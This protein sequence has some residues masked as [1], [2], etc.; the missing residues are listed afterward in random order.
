MKSSQSIILWN[1]VHYYQSEKFSKKSPLVFLHGWGQNGACFKK[2]FKILDEKNISYIALD[3]PWFGKTPLKNEQMH[4]EDYGHFVE[5]FIE[6]F[7][8][9]H[10]LLIWHSFGGRIC[11]YLWSYYTN[12]S[13]IILIWSAGLKSKQNY[14]KLAIIKS[15]KYIFKI[16]GLKTL[17]VK[18]R[19][20]AIS[21][22]NK[23]AGKMAKIFMHTINNDLKKYMVKIKIP[24]LLIRWENDDQTPLSE[25]Q[26]INSQITDSKLHIIKK[27]TH[28]V[29][30]EFPDTVL[31]MI[32][33]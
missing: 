13:K 23:N 5:A 26:I 16:P 28:F 1:V 9:I 7:E 21:E 8:L 20:A 15:G 22:D 10:P 3:L 6:K 18:I 27:G 17:W 29:Y 14:L 32:L 24:T 30:D 33:D 19:N 25:A 12:I 31:K 2:I 11:I 4:I